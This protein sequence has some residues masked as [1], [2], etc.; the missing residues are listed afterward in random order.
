MHTRG[1]LPAARTATPPRP[2]ARLLALAAL[3]LLFPGSAFGDEPEFGPQDIPTVFFI[4]KSDDH[5]RVDYGMR[6][7]AACSPA[8]ESPVFPYWRE[9]ENAPPVR[10]HGLKWVE[11]FAY[12][13]A[14][15]RVLRRKPS[16]GQVTMR[17]RPLAR[18]IFITSWRDLEGRCRA[19]VY[20]RIA[21]ISGAELLSVHVTL[22]A[23]MQVDLHGRDPITGNPVDERL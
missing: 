23:Q 2:P 18:D 15:Q 4:D 1:R 10:T 17:L 21:N 22:G 5:N 14:E 19:A 16:G 13:V 8:A 12:G 3:P 6:L 20:T 7:D 9:F 11:F